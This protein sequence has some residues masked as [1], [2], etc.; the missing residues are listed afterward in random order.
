MGGPLAGLRVLELATGVSGPYAARLF[1]MLGAE[2]MKVEPDGGDPARRLAVD[3]HPPDTPVSPLFVHLN[4]G[5]R[6]VPLGSVGSRFADL[7]EWADIVVDSRVRT[8]VRASSTDVEALAQHLDRR[9]VIA[10]TTAWGCSADD[11]GV[12]SDEL[13][14]QS[15]SGLMSATGDEGREPL[16]FP[17]WQSQY[18]AGGYLAAAALGLLHATKP[19][20]VEVSWV[21][22]ALTAVEGGACAYLQPASAPARGAAT[23]GAEDGASK[24][25][26]FQVGAFPSGAFRCADGHVIPGTV[27]A[28]DWDLQCEVYGRPD[29]RDD[30]RFSW[31][32]RWT[33]RELLRAELQPWYDERTK[34][35]IF[36]A[37]LDA[38]WAAAMVMTAGDALDDPHLAERRFLSA[39]EG[40]AA[41]AVVPGRPWRS[42]SIVEGEPVTL[43]SGQDAAELDLDV[44][45]AGSG[46][47]RGVDV[48]ALKVLELTWAWAGPFV[49]RFLGALGADVV[50]V[51]A[52]RYPDGWRTRLRW[53]DAGVDV[54]EGVDAGEYTWDAAA[55]FNSLNRNKRGV[56]IDLATEHG[57]EAFLDLLAQADVLVANMTYSVLADRRIDVEVQAAVERGLVFANMPALGAT[58]RYRDMPG[59][60]MLMEGM[61]GFSARFGYRDEGARA[62][63]TY[64]PDAV[65]GIHG[66]VAVLA[67]L[68][69]RERTGRG[70][71][72]DLSQQ[73]TTWLQYGEGIAL[74]SITGR[75]PQRLGNGEPRTCVSGV[76]PTTDGYV[77]V[78]VD[79]ESFDALASVAQPL[80]PFAT[81]SIEQ[82]LAHREALDVAMAE[83]TSTRSVVQVVEALVHLD[84]ARAMRCH[85]FRTG[86]RSGE[87]EQ[88]GLL[89]EVEH[90]VTGRRAYVA[91]PVRID[92]RAVASTRPAPAFAQHTDEVLT[93]WAGYDAG[94]LAH[95]RAAEAI[96]TVPRAR[97]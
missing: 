75:E 71:T 41:G 51:E 93:E 39:V 90:P 24:Q 72:I 73:E 84:G 28:I 58:G 46:R 65:A 92:G 4:A 61:G 50:R 56:S 89:D 52:G 43:S 76:Y 86:Y 68:T 11:A 88:R 33:N 79:E 14:V 19:V 38:G 74:R 32:M 5:K 49:G 22:A 54:P 2:V 62:S 16:R 78:V 91:L 63:T 27:R 67:A 42:E 60:G 82:R 44:D 69:E 35:E 36:H 23:G 34:H 13:I 87:F 83:W 17:G 77:A 66:S 20:H 3:D 6:I 96:G 30:E 48:S 55:L 25:A 18:L 70:A 15:A 1:A 40:A 10:S 37:A 59:Y 85:T 47:V 45:R 21:G 81:T 97:R 94:R 26:G 31:R 8:E 9:L 57:R 53:S 80:A 64:Y 29:L 12:P 7:L 95:L